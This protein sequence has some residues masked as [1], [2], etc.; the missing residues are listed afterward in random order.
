MVVKARRAVTLG[1]AAVA[2]QGVREALRM[3]EMFLYLRSYILEQSQYI[4]LSRIQ[5]FR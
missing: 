3:L 1:K 4:I 5:A 2:G